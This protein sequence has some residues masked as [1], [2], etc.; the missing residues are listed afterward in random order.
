[1]PGDYHAEIAIS[2]GGGVRGRV[3]QLTVRLRVRYKHL[4]PLPFIGAFAITLGISLRVFDGK[5]STLVFSLLEGLGGI[6]GF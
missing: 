1:L 5:T 6:R 3:R 2:D 4:S